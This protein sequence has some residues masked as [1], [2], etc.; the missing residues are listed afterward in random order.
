MGAPKVAVVSAFEAKLQPILAAS[1]AGALRAPGREVSAWD[2]DVFP[3]D[4]PG[5][6]FDLVLISSRPMRASRPAPSSQPVPA[7]GRPAGAGRR[8]V[9]LAER[10][11]A[12]E[13]DRRRGGGRAEGHDRARELAY[14]AGQADITAAAGRSSPGTAPAPA[15]APHPAGHG[16]CLP[17]T[18][19]S[20]SPTIP[21]TDTR[22]GLLGNIE[23]TRGCHHRCGYCAVYAAYGVAAIP[24]DAARCS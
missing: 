2:A 17:A 23:A 20:R 19:S 10:S 5:G 24:V 11:R 8:A 1:A 12:R 6:D 7:G 16:S 22:F 15:Q 4:F 13:R 18:C 3:N 9:R 21:S 14:A